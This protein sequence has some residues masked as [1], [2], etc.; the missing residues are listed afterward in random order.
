[1]EKEILHKKLSVF[2]SELAGLFVSEATLIQV[3]AGKEI[4]REN[5]NVSQIPLVVSGLVKVYGK[6]DDKELLLYYIQPLESCIMSFSASRQNQKS[7]VFAV[8][9]K[10]SEILLI[11]AEKLHFWLISHPALHQV[12]YRE[13]D[14][15]YEDLLLSL[16][17]ILY[18]NIETRLMDY[19]VQKARVL[20]TQK[21][22][23]SPSKVAREL[24]TAREVISR[25]VRKLHQENKIRLENNWIILKQA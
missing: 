11:P 5:Q 8:T 1:M 2:G 24:G 9:E 6:F 25:I 18:R 10:P 4:L 22:E 13:Y 3:E 12:F 21:I 15:R 17:S 19:I 20:Q 23:F 16:E 7:K 14:K